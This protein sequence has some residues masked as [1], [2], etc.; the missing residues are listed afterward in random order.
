[1][2]SPCYVAALRILKYRFNSETE[3]RR[4]LRA[5]K[6]ER[7]D[8]DLAIA[9]LHLE[10]WLDDKRFAGAFVRTRMQKSIGR[11]RIRRE[12]QAAG[13]NDEDAGRAVSE[14]VDPEREQDDLVA[15][16]RKR[17]RA[18]ARRHGEAF[19]STEEGHAKIASWLLN[20][21]YESARVWETVKTE[22]RI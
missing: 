15:A 7:E 4:K 10:K 22:T 14:N 9:R 21:G 2:D 17:M 8:I 16:C 6:F 13:V 3:L 18:L 11:L 20:R 5:K 1:M 12:L 19:L